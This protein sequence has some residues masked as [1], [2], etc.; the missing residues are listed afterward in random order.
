MKLKKVTSNN[1]SSVYVVRLLRGEEIIH[2]LKN[3]G[4]TVCKGKHFATV[5][6]IGSVKSPKIGFYDNEKYTERILLGTYEVLN[7]T[8]NITVS[9]DKVFPHIHIT[10][11]NYEYKA[12]GGH[13]FEAVTNETM[14]LIITVYN[15]SVKRDYDADTGG[16]YLINIP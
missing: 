13:L 8:G 7:L 5:T 3:F 10:V 6:G 4:N 9:Q 2:S 12:F 16:L 15:T 14:E 11:S 1:E